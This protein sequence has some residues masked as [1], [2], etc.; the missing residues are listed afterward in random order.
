MATALS[1]EL[2]RVFFSVDVWILFKLFIVM[3]AAGLFAWWQTKLM[4]QYKLDGPDIVPAASALGVPPNA[5]G[6]S[7]A[8]GARDR[9]R[10]NRT[11]TPNVK[12]PTSVTY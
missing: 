6:A 7:D 3:P 4:A 8:A 10:L 12:R 5:G 9:T 1:N 2:V 11:A